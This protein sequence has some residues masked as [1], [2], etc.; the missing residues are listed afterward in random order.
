MNYLHRYIYY[1]DS[2]LL[3]YYRSVHN[4]V[5]HQFTTPIL[6]ILYI[7]EQHI[8]SSTSSDSSSSTIPSAFAILTE[9]KQ[10]SIVIPK[11]NGHTIEYTIPYTTILPRRAHTLTLHSL[12]SSSSTSPNPQPVI[13]VGDKI[14]DVYAVPYPD[15]STKR[16]Y[17]LTHTGSILTCVTRGLGQFSNTLLSADRD[18]KIRV[19]RWPSTFVIDAFCLGHTRYISFMHINEHIPLTNYQASDILLTG[20]GD[21]TIRVWYYKTGSLL[22]TLYLGTIAQDKIQNNNKDGKILSA[23][24]PFAWASNE[25]HADAFMSQSSSEED[26]DHSSNN[27]NKNNN[28]N[29]QNESNTTAT[30]TTNT[31][32]NTDNQ[33]NTVDNTNDDDDSTTDNTT[34]IPTIPDTAVGFTI[35]PVAPAQVPLNI[36]EFTTTDHHTLLAVY[37]EGEKYVRILKL[38]TNT[39]LMIPIDPNQVKGTTDIKL[40]PST[41]LPQVRM[42]QIGYIT[43]PMDKSTVVLGL[44]KLKNNHNQ[45][46]LAVCTSHSNN[47]NSSSF[48]IYS[49]T[50]T[51][52]PTTS[53]I[54]IHDHTNIPGITN[55]NTY[56]TNTTTLQNINYTTIHGCIMTLQS[57]DYDKRGVAII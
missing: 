32:S 34:N 18:E 51:Y 16:R 9:D 46:I 39:D 45:D 5:S 40:Q 23:V 19:S 50:V 49:Y 4:P 47:N 10:L 25:S 30:T 12:P 37:V 8:F 2:L 41:S 29:N 15:I 11:L 31:A 13:I 27:N 24:A 7:P 54:H 36:I 3:L 20:S 56:F 52:N 17:L 22:H 57:K 14:G 21:G 28:T 38:Y 26:Q 42:E 48:V 53:T 6:A 43:L 44:T 33:D 35:E 1:I 55:L